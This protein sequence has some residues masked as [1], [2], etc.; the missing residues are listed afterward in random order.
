MSRRSFTLIE[1]LIVIA[2]I[3][4]LLSLLLP[5]LSKAREAS[6]T[7]VCLSNLRQIGVGVY[8]YSTTS[9]GVIPIVDAF[10]NVMVDAE[11]IEAPRK[12]PMS[13]NLNVEVTKESSVFRCPSGKTDRL[14]TNMLNGKWS[15]IDRDETLRPW[16]SWNGIAEGNTNYVKNAGGIDSWYGVVGSATNKGGS[17]TW[18]YNNWRVA[19]A[20]Q[21][22]PK[23]DY[24]STPSQGLT[25]HDGSCYVHTHSG[26]TPGRIS[27]RH[28]FGK[29]T[30]LLFFDGHAIQESY[31]NVLGS[32]TNTPDTGGKIIWKSVKGF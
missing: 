16:R 4:I 5:S 15:F 7:A 24:I 25:I 23:M 3:G 8:N 26:G 21:T 12:T 10:T 18:R 2:I 13:G 9:N 19:N 6:K 28:K 32:R 29:T 31:G 22:W 11:V 20:N 17:G 14:S 1:L 27:P 30:N